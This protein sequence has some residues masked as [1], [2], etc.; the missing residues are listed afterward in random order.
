[1][2]DTKDGNMFGIKPVVGSK[3]DGVGQGGSNGTIISLLKRLLGSTGLGGF[4]F[5]FDGGYDVY[6]EKS[7]HEIYEIEHHFH[8]NEKYFG[9]AGTPAGETHR[10]DRITLKPNPFIADAGNDDWG[11]WL[12]V[13]GSSDTPV[14]ANMIHFDFHQ[15]LIVDHETNTQDYFMQIVCGEEADIPAKLAAEEF[16]EFAF[17]SGGGTS[18]AGAQEVHGPRYE[19][20]DK[21]WVR[22]WADGQNTSTL[23]FYFAMHEYVY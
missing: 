23:N 1:M 7:A 8:S 14:Q 20:G 4:S 22:I 18:E 21:L 13:M 16:T 12:Q 2:S 5:G 3:S 10:A 9:L 19:S 11:A 17:V 15:L 6:N